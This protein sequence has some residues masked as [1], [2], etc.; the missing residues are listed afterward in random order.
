MFTHTDYL[1]FEMTEQDITIRIRYSGGTLRITDAKLSWTFENL[2]NKVRKILSL[3]ED[4]V[5][6]LST[7]P[8]HG[9]DMILDDSLTLKQ[10]GFS[11]GTLLFLDSSKLTTSV[12][13]LSGTKNKSIDATGNIVL[14]KTSDPAAFR[15]GLLSLR[16]QKMHWTLTEMTELE[17]NYTFIIKGKEPIYCESTTLDHESAEKFQNYC[18]SFGFK[19]PRAAFM[20]GKF[21]DLESK[22]IE[23]S[24]KP[25][26][27]GETKG[28]MR[29]SDFKP[30]D[31][32]KPKKAVI[33]DCIYDPKQECENGVDFTVDF[34]DN[35]I[36]TAMKI[37]NSL[38]LEWV[39]FIFSHPLEH[40]RDYQQFPLQFRHL[41]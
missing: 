26:R 21:I 36:Q 16:S 4:Q 6:I 9:T 12:A 31:D 34:S 40:V 2:K 22:E 13:P 38:G 1:I 27:Y 29:V 14:S 32:T 28:A 19:R 33:V 37:G 24:K 41:S 35:E 18:N 30:D 39:G 5:V 20:F 3:P 7:T 10:C 25:K 15:P 8:S 17:N 23:Y 11:H